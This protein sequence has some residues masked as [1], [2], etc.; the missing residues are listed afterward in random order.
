MTSST[1]CKLA[2]CNFSR[3]ADISV[4]NGAISNHRASDSSRIT[5]GHNIIATL[6]QRT[7]N[8]SGAIYIKCLS[9]IVFCDSN[10]STGVD[11]NTTSAISAEAK[12]VSRFKK[13]TRIGVRVKRK[14]WRGSIAVTSILKQVRNCDFLCYVCGYVN[15]RK[16]ISARRI[17]NRI[18]LCDFDVSH[19]DGL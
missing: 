10:I 4:H 6:R 13:N 5:N 12:L 18:K 14:S 19:G 3:C 7:R 2:D 11:I 9:R 16:N 8:R 1:V 15:N 17:G